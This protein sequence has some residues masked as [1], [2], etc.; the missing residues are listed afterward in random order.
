MKMKKIQKKNH[1]KGLTLCM[2]PWIRSRLYVL[3]EVLV[4]IVGKMKDQRVLDM[5]GD[6]YLS[7]PLR[8]SYCAIDIT[9]AVMGLCHKIT[10][11]RSKST[12]VLPTTQVTFSCEVNLS[13]R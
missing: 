13:R 10:Y 8:D 1:L 6:I 9:T 2:L 12:R 3:G 7:S 4:Y 5:L 11:P